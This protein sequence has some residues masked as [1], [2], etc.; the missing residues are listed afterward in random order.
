MSEM[1]TKRDIQ[2]ITIEIRQLTKSAQRMALEYSI[3]IGH[4]L[5]EAKS[6]LAH[7]EWGR[8]L[9]EEVEFSQSTANNFMR[10]YE[11]YGEDQLTLDGA[12]VK[13]QTLGNLSPSQALALLAVPSEERESFVLENDL[14]SKSSREIQRLIRERD[15][16]QKEAADYAEQ[17]SDAEAEN[18]RLTSELESAKDETQAA[19]DDAQAYKKAAENEALLRK[20][21]EAANQKAEKA[22]EA[23]KKAKDALKALKE[24]PV[25]SEDVMDKLRADA[26]IAAGEEVKKLKEQLQAAAEQAK[27][28][29]NSANETVE[30]LKKKLAAAGP[31]MVSFRVIFEEIQQNF[32]KLCGIVLRV[33]A[34]DTEQAKKLRSAMSAML[35]NFGRQ[36]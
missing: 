21:L 16:A 11:E 10:L 6:M 2:T 17:L 24:N 32:N 4:R 3:E 1:I 15:Q 35:E 14:E 27:K 23:E 18:E 29:L 12:V 22:K 8:W 26:K 33:E 7:G 20:E 9:K 34:N 28:E 13:S 36:V 25:V 19:K 30:S 5:C 31:D